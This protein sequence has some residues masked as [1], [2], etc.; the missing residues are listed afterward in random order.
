MTFV[1]ETS[2]VHAVKGKS[3]QTALPVDDLGPTLAVYERFRETVGGD[4]AAAANLTLAH[5]IWTGQNV[6]A[7]CG[8]ERADGM[9]NLKQAAK[10]IGISERELRKTVDRTR[11]SREGVRVQ[12]PTIEYF[13]TRKNASILFKPE[14]LEAYVER[15]HCR[16]GALPMPAPRRHRKVASSRSTNPLVALA[17]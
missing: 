1:Q 14:W 9:L 2:G 10:H 12:G 13:Q 6:R 11:R 7:S 4:A 16:A 3:L 17:Q 5:A 15:Y 8:R